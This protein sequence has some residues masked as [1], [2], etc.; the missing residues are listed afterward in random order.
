[1]RTLNDIVPPSR[2][3][4]MEPPMSMSGDPSNREPL[5]L[6]VERRSRFPY[7]TLLI[8]A[9]VIIASLGA[10]F[11]F[12][13]AEVDVTPSSVSAQVQ[14]TFTAST[15]G[16]TGTLPFQIITAQKIAS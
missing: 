2:R 13:K 7:I 8:V 16:G 1:M 5:N 6:A 11:Y 9:L 14:G 12:S 3:K 4:E 10:L 15:S